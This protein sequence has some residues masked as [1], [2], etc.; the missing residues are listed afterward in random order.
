M[1]CRGPEPPD[2]GSVPGRTSHG[3]AASEALHGSRPAIRPGGP[4]WLKPGGGPGG[5]NDH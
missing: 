3:A 5:G 1:A 4:G 2:H